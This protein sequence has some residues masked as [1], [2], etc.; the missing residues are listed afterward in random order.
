MLTWDILL[1]PKDVVVVGNKFDILPETVL[2]SLW[3][4]LS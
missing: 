2:Q 3:I 1:V 4:V